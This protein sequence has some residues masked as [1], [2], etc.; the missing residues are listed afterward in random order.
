MKKLLKEAEDGTK[1]Q[2]ELNQALSQTNK[3]NLDLKLERDGQKYVIDYQKEERRQWMEML[4]KAMEATAE[5]KQEIRQ[6][7]QIQIDHTRQIEDC[8]QRDNEKGELIRNFETRLNVLVGMLQKANLPLPEGFIWS[9][10][11]ENGI[12]KEN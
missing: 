12:S 2:S 1:R 8:T 9:N 4:Q 7:K 5:Q 11:V 10:I 3:E 6:M